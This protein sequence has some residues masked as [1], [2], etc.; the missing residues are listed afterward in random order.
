MPGKTPTDETPLFG[1]A[2]S[3]E[4]LGRYDE[5]LELY[6][7]IVAANPNAEEPMANMVHIGM[8]KSDQALVRETSEKLLALRPFS[9]AALE[10]LAWC[11][12]AGEDYDAASKY[13][14][15]LVE[16]TPEHFER[17]YNLGV[18]CQ[19]LNKL[20]QAEKAYIEAGRLKPE[21]A[22]TWANLGVVRQ[23][24][25]NPKG[26][27]EAYE[28]ALKLKSDVPEVLSISRPAGRAGPDHRLK[29]CTTGSSKRVPHGRRWFRSVT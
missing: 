20:E 5:S 15:K 21:H 4:L 28:M 23:S 25:T 18:A 12:F 13:C 3:L 11:A 7:K 17:W 27:R 6:R 29:T 19:K 16:L 2:V 9:Q 22:Q 8:R 1:K 14:A 24:M 26:A 10:G